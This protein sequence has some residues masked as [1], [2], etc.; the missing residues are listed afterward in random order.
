VSRHLAPA[1]KAP[2]RG[3]NTTKKGNRLEARV[4]D[5]LKGEIAQNRFFVTA[6][7]CKIFHKKGYYSRERQKK[8]V[9][10]ISIEVFQPGEV[11][12]SLLILVECKNYNH[13][14]PVKDVEVL[15]TQ[16]Q[17]VSGANVKGILVATHK[18]QE[19]TFNF[20]RSKGI[21]LMRY[22]NST[23]FKWIL[24]RSPS[25]LVS[26]TFAAKEQQIAYA[27]ITTESYQSRLFDCYCYVDDEYTVS[28]HRLLSRL[29]MS[30]AE[31]KRPV[32][33]SRPTEDRSESRALVPYMAASKIEERCEV[34]LDQIGYAGGEVP[35]DVV[36]QWVSK[37]HGLR[38]SRDKPRLKGQTG[39]EVLGMISF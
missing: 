7:R 4:L 3:T 26:S 22:Y 8:I 20:S 27:G 31:K 35:I 33:P 19:G 9:F 18:F 29:S 25:T 36:C 21:A 38:V 11:A 5:L 17:Q 32:S 15:H 10:D 30:D 6:D 37:E 28:L 24:N 2:K 12:Y 16:M 39:G 1:K 34:I 14:V 13:P 23:K